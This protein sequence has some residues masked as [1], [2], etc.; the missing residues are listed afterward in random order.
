[1]ARKAITDQPALAECSANSVLRALRDC[2]T[3]GLELGH[4]SS[5]I[6]RRS[7]Q[8]LPIAHWDAS[9]AGMTGLAL[10]SGYVRS[11]DAQVV[12]EHDSFRVEFGSSP[13]LVHVPSLSGERGEVIAAYAVAMLTS[14]VKVIELLTREDLKRI[15]A[16]SPAGERG[17][18]GPWPCE[19]AR[20]SATRRLLKR[21]PAG[22]RLAISPL[23]DAWCTE[24]VEVPYVATTSSLL[25]EEQHVLECRALEQLDAASTVAALDAAW[26]QAELAF[27]QRNVAV[28]PT[29]KARWRE[30]REVQESSD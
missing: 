5:L 19:M 15:K 29:V 27:K 17:P 8:G 18:W 1:L 28:S 25:P 9:Y 6:I 16:M 3:S 24:A 4:F 11:V 20:K 21:L 12:R 14:G 13:M 7:K 30:L 10:A 26:A 2:A 22:T 23:D